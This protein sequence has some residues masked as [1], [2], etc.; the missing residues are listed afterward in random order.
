MNRILHTDIPILAGALFKLERSGRYDEAIAELGSVWDNLDELPEL[1]GLDI[2]DSAELLLRCGALLGF[3]GSIKV[4][5]DAQERSKNLLTAA[6]KRFLK[7]SD[8]TKIAEC[9]NYLALTYTRTGEFVEAETFVDESLSHDLPELS[10]TR[11]SA[12]LTKGLIYITAHR[13][14]DAVEFL[15]P[16]E[17][18]FRKFGNPYLLG[19][20]CTNMAVAL[21]NT[22]RREEGL[23]Y[24][25]AARS[26]HQKSG[27]QIY[28]GTVENNLCFAYAL[29]KRFHEAHRA[30]DNAARIFR[31]TN[32]R[33]REGYCYDSKAQ[34]FL[35]EGRVGSAL[36]TI[37]KALQI[38]RPS[39]NVAWLVDSIETKA[40]I[41]VRSEGPTA[42]FVCLSEAVELAK[43]KI[44]EE[45]AFALVR[46]FEKT[47]KA[48]DIKPVGDVRAQAGAE[49]IELVLDPTLAN[50][51]DYQGVW[52]KNPN[53]ERFGLRHGSLAVVTPTKIKRGDLIALSERSTGNVMC[54]FY[55]ADFGIICLEGIGD[56][57]LLFN[58]QEVDVLGKVIGVGNPDGNDDGK[59][60]ISPLNL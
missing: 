53:L 58:D 43:S 2:R 26:H 17:A 32:D 12:M 22:G 31:R 47:L 1:D 44:N 7:I 30:V 39:D 36:K 27:H 49:S 5:R 9:E 46:N 60:H 11:I 23:R 15:T 29:E 56:E 37:E 10:D 19:S 50:F 38:L 8:I 16:R 40:R 59:I 57:P 14:T 6:H 42:A 21:R 3:Y 51:T 20:F 41:L 28:L 34:L 35:D 54:G 48:R 25:E 13:F 24:L 4:A 33:M 52:I 55:D 18:V 45:R